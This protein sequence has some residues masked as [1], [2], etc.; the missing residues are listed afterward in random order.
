MEECISR[1]E[2]GVCAAWGAFLL[3]ASE[4][5]EILKV[6]YSTRPHRFGVHV[7]A[8][9]N[10]LYDC[11]C[12]SSKLKTVVPIYRDTP[13]NLDQMCCQILESSSRE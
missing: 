7:K 13:R 5:F 2:G 6:S 8:G 3:G 12:H 10:S 4:C 9:V 11:Q 1:V